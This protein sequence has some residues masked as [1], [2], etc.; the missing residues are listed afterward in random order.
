MTTNRLRLARGALLATVLVLV[1]D[2]G[3]GLYEHLVID[4]AWVGNPRLVQAAADGIDRKLFWIPIHGAL[5]LAF[6]VAIGASWSDRAAPR[7]P[8]RRPRESLPGARKSVEERKDP[9][10]FVLGARP[11]RSVPG[12][13]R[14]ESVPGARKSVESSGG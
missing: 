6:M 2:L 5:T 10:R 7:I 12:A 14:E 9:R 8:P 3:G 1:L 4:T 13:D 11:R